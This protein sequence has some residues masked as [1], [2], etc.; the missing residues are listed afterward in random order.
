MGRKEAGCYVLSSYED[1]RLRRQKGLHD[2][3]T[4]SQLIDPVNEALGSSKSLGPYH[5]VC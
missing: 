1:V 5:M 2:E 4:G 3:E